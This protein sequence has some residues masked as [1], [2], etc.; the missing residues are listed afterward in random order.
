MLLNI[1]DYLPIWFF[2]V[3]IPVILLLAFEAG[4]NTVIDNISCRKNNI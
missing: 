1:F 2:Y 3:G 4:Y